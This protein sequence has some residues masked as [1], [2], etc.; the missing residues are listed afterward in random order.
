MIRFVIN[1]YIYVIIA[2][3]IISFIPQYA[4]EPW[5]RFINKL[6]NYTL[7]PVRKI[8]PRDLPFDF[9]P[10]IVIIVLQLIPTL[11]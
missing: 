1:L 4:H 10:I 7:D 9:S 11:W 8:L 2:D 3:V 5:A 6:A